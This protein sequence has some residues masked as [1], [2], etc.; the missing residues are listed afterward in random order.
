MDAVE[1]M[2]GDV[3]TRDSQLGSGRTSCGRAP[4]SKSTTQAHLTVG[5]CGEERT[6]VAR[7]VEEG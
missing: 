2:D 1:A 6:V 3:L 7:T 5:L 4:D